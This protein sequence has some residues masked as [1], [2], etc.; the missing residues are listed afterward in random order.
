MSTTLIH[1][2]VVSQ[3]ITEAFERFDEEYLPFLL[4]E[5]FVAHPWATLDLPRGPEGMIQVVRRLR[6]LFAH[7]QVTV[8][9]LVAEGDRVVARY[10]FEA[11]YVAELAGVPA[12]GRR[13]RM[14]GILIA[15]MDGGKIAEY[16]REEDQLGMLRQLGV[17]PM[18]TAAMQPAA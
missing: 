10:R 13:V 6:T 18:P 2:A 3:F 15:R 4:S 16:W 7:P 8:G 11:D 17:E 1:K 9:D 5:D 12:G 14:D